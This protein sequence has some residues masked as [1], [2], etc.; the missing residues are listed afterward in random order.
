MTLGHPETQIAVM[1]HS[2]TLMEKIGQLTMICGVVGDIGGKDNGGQPELASY[3]LED[4]RNGLVGSILN[5]WGGKG[6]ERAQ[7]AAKQS[8]LGI[9]VMTCFDVLHGYETTF[10]IPLGEAAAFDPELWQATATAAAAEA[11]SACI[12]L[13]FAPMLDV[14]RDARWGRMAESFGEDPWL[15]VRFAA[16]KVRGFQRD[17]S[18][19]DTVAATAKHLGAYGAVTAG[20]EYNS[21]DISSR[22]LH[23]VHLPAF[24]AAVKAGVAAV[25]PSFNDLAGVPMTAHAGML[26]GVLRERFGFDGVIISDF[27]ATAELIVH[28]VAADL[29][30]AAALSIKAG[31]DIDM[32][33]DVY[34]K[35]LPEALDR[36]LITIDLIDQAVTRVLRLK[37]RLGLLDDAFRGRGGQGSRM[38]RPE[39]RALAREAAR[40]SMVLLQN[41]G[42]LLPLK[43]GGGKLA[44]VGPFADSLHD[45][46][47]PWR[48]AA[49]A[50]EVIDFVTGLRAE[51]PGWEI[52]HAAGSYVRREDPDS[53]TAAIEAARKADVV[54]L[55]LGES[56]DM[57]GEAGSRTSPD[58]PTAQRTLAE[59]V[60][61]LRK[62]VV[63]TIN[64]GRPLTAPWLFEQADAVLAVWFPG[65]EA[66]PALA[67]I[68][69][70]RHAPTA[71]LPVSWPY[72]V[73]QMPIFY[74]QRPTG[75]PA[76]PKNIMTSRYIDAPVEPQFAFGHGLTY[77]R[78][79]YR[80]LRVSQRFAGRGE[81]VM[82]EADIANEGAVEVTET[83]FLF[84]RDPVASISRPM[85][86]LKGV[87]R[88]KLA[89]GESGTVRFPLTAEDTAFLDDHGMPVLESGLI[90][91][92]VGPK[93]DKSVLLKESIELRIA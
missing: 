73:G 31:I 21:V 57:A 81:T 5:V 51:L 63:V 38:H 55:C 24:A 7:E 4:V 53:F 45:N 79:A 64:S 30:E 88:L 33:S 61:A 22:T 17:F 83:A 9:P 72:A 58:I 56:S 37:A 48:A 25:M 20:R 91:I 13:T 2:M 62:P 71:K 49:E 92:F 74:S 68:L 69:T 32:V 67:D 50:K 42:D 23:E 47:G 27:S 85:L 66:G 35:G 8:R 90:E 77:T 39:H 80:A 60:F 76:D 84:I 86:E 3:Q 82:V 44:V 59:A 18:G 43:S 41:R 78:I 34:V 16:A 54:L 70:G 36:G 93:A 15:G 28:G 29:A 11:A 75:R 6:I 87:E 89:P 26:R 1:L 12:D 65:S 19:A 46:L 10:P 52:L 14:A 40:R